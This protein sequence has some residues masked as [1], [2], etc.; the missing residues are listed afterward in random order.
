MEGQLA[1]QQRNLDRLTGEL[2][3]GGRLLVISEHWC[4][5]RAGG[6]SLGH[7]FKDVELRVWC[8]HTNTS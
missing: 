7:L 3:H 4:I 1:E 6:S 8:K 5:K 2:G